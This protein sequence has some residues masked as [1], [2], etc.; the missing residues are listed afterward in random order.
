MSVASEIAAYKVQ[1][2]TDVTSKTMINTISPENVGDMGT[3]LADLIL[4]WLEIVEAGGGA[5]W[6]ETYAPTTEGEN[7]D[8]WFRISGGQ[9]FV[10]RKEAGTW[11]AY[12]NLSIGI[13]FPDG[14]L[15][16]LRVNVNG[17][18]VIVTAGGW[19]IDNVIYQKLTETNFT[20]PAA[21]LNFYR[22]DLIYADINSDILYLEGV[23]ASTPNFPATPAD[24]IVV[25]YIIV[26]PSSSGQSP[27]SFYGGG[28]STPDSFLIS[29]TSDVNGEFDVS[30]YPI[31]EF[32]NVT[33]YD[34]NGLQSP[35]Q[36]SN[37]DKKIYFLNPSET[38]NARFT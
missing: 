13:V 38:F 20:V 6:G 17:F 32:P 35:A 23:A 1:V 2:V 18:D 8:W 19:V 37:T 25:D 16:N 9:F 22:Y 7:G 34:T 30:S 12:V 11:N 14:P 31:G 21:D 15:I 26:P 3:D 10:Y 5:I 27:Y 29:G 36:Y 28:M 33:I 4:P 24:S